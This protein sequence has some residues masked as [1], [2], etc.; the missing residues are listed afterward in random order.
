MDHPPKNHWMT[1]KKLTR[2][3]SLKKILK[4]VTKKGTKTMIT[5]WRSMVSRSMIFL[6]HQP[7]RKSAKPPKRVQLKRCLL[8][9]FRPSQARALKRLVFRG[10]HSTRAS[11]SWQRKCSMGC[12][13]LWL[14]QPLRKSTAFHKLRWFQQL[15]SGDSQVV[16][17]SNPSLNCHLHTILASLKLHSRL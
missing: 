14:N 11:E 17:L 5:C 12:Q 3:P 16:H 9:W 4:K 2:S 6:R 8:P 13:N 7:E 15:N 10:N 1:S